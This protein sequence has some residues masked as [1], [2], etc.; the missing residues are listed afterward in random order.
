[1]PDTRKTKDTRKRLSNLTLRVLF[2]VC[3]IPILLYLLFMAPKWGFLSLLVVACI[4]SS[5]ELFRM[6]AP[7]R[8]LLMT[9]GAISSTAVFYFFSFSNNPSFLPLVIII[10]VL[11][12][13]SMGLTRPGYIDEAVFHV[14]W[15]IAGPLYLGSTLGS[16]ALLFS[17]QFGGS[18]VLFAAM[19]SWFGDTGA[20]FGGRAF[21]KHKLHPSISPKKTVEGA[22]F[23]LLSSMAGGLVAHLWL[24]PSLSLVESVVLASVAGASGQLGDLCESL[25]KRRCGVKDSG[26]I[27]PGHGG[28]LDRIDSLLFSSSV[29]WIYVD[30]L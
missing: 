12:S 9:F 1:M 13:L 2:A 17:R 28:L 23:G 7:G 6:I 5:V 10:L 29:I 14:G 8:L 20:Y 11:S 16:L 21:G 30:W 24:L 18:W 3:A 26:T 4:V 19:T 27:I 25:V 22:V 15:L